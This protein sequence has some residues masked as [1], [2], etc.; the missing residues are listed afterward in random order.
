[1]YCVFTFQV[2]KLNKR[3]ASKL[4]EGTEEGGVDLEASMISEAVDAG[5]VLRKGFFKKRGRLNVAL[6]TRFFVLTGDGLV[7]YYESAADFQDLHAPRGSFS[8]FD[9]EIFQNDCCDGFT[10]DGYV[11]TLCVSTHSNGKQ[12]RI[13]CVC[14][15]EKERTEWV[16]ALYAAGAAKLQEVRINAEPMLLLLQFQIFS[17]VSGVLFW[18]SEH[19][20]TL[21]L[22]LTCC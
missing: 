22:L 4:P 13:E 3:L 6:K 17:R 20:H 16:A 21:L 15:S 9:L 18:D 5:N 1:V 10:Q 11:F 12:K 8:C 7:R 19:K 2:E 14:P